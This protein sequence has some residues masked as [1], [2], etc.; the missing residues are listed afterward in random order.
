M[1]NIEQIRSDVFTAWSKVLGKDNADN[2]H[3]AAGRSFLGQP[4]ERTY[5]DSH[6]GSIVGSDGSEDVACEFI[7]GCHLSAS[8]ICY[9]PSSEALLR[10]VRFFRA[11]VAGKV[12]VVKCHIIVKTTCRTFEG[13]GR[14][15][16]FTGSESEREGGLEFLFRHNYSDTFTAC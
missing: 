6:P 5:L 15:I 8:F 3:G 4:F 16:A 14:H 7:N 13:I 2:E 11:D 10:C 9:V 1:D 12:G